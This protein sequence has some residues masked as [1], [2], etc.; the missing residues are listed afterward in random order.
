MHGKIRGIL[1]LVCPTTSTVRHRYAGNQDNLSKTIV[2]KICHHLRSAEFDACHSFLL[3]AFT[4][5]NEIGHGRQAAFRSITS[6][7]ISRA[8]ALAKFPGSG[9]AQEAARN[10]MGFKIQAEQSEFSLP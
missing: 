8:G 2:L 10:K 4:I 3:H 6:L 9:A 7:E 1:L 5:R